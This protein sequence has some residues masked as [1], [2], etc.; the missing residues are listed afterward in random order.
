[1]TGRT[2][3]DKTKKGS[4]RF[5]VAWEETGDGFLSQGDSSGQSGNAGKKPGIISDN[6]SM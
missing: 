5:S 6:A 4:G 2:R 1:M 3:R